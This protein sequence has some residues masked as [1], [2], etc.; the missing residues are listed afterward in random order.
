[1]QVEQVLVVLEG[2]QELG[3]LVL[4]WLLV[5]VEVVSGKPHT[6]TVTA[7]VEAVYPV[8]VVR[9]PMQA[10]DY[11]RPMCHHELNRREVSMHYIWV[12]KLLKETFL[13]TKTCLQLH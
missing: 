5:V 11:P 13:P 1:M 2:V 7:A 9:Q 12:A 4:V 6:A 10:T 8:E 3:L